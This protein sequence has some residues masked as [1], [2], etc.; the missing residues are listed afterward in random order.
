VTVEDHYAGGGLGGAVLEA[1]ALDAVRARQLAVNEVP[2]SGTS[3][4]LLD[5]YGIN[6]HHIVRAVLE[7]SESQ[8]S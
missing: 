8:P 7:L 5:R 4:E 3:A 6:A 2:R 1:L